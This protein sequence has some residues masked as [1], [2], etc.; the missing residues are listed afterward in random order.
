MIRRSA[1]FIRKFC[2]GYAILRAPSVVHRSLNR[3][4]VR[5]GSG[6]KRTDVPVQLPDATTPWSLAA[7]YVFSMRQAIV[8]GPVPPGIGV[9]QPATSLTGP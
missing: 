1:V 5:L 8:I 3:S 2:A 9:I 6:P 4:S 7:V